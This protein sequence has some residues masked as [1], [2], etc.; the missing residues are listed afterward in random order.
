M[1]CNLKPPD[2]KPLSLT[3]FPPHPHTALPAAPSWLILLRAFSARPPCT[4]PAPA[5][6][7]PLLPLASP[8]AAS[9]SSRTPFLSSLRPVRVTTALRMVLALHPFHLGSGYPCPSLAPML[10]GDPWR[11]SWWALAKQQSR[12]Q[13]AKPSI[14]ASPPSPWLFGSSVSSLPPSWVKLRD[15]AL[16]VPVA[17]DTALS[18][19]THSLE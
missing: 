5:P 8:T 11:P 18:L 3:S 1:V 13:K 7:R 16:G 17:R 12:W 4:V 2:L 19:E 15:R 14:P 6:A 10:H 9:L